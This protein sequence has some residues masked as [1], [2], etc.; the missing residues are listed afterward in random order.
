MVQEEVP[1]GAPKDGTSL[2]PESFLTKTPFSCEGQFQ[3]LD[4][5][6]KVMC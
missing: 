4:S 5:A 1:G 3:F 2:T 6:R